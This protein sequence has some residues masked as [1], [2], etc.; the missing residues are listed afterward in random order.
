[1]VYEVWSPIRIEAMNIIDAALS[2][3]IG[4]II[5]ASDPV[6]FILLFISFYCPEL[7]PGSVKEAKATA[8]AVKVTVDTSSPEHS[9][10]SLLIHVDTVNVNIPYLSSEGSGVNG[11]P[12]K[13]F[14]NY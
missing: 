10:T 12:P 8:D 1:V 14:Q 2:G 4:V 7:I 6:Y 5:A 3:S 13:V 11:D 9:A